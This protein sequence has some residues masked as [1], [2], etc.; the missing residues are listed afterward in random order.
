MTSIDQARTPKPSNRIGGG[1]RFGVPAAIQGA[2]ASRIVAN[3]LAGKDAPVIR[4]NV[5]VE[6]WTTKTHDVVRYEELE[7]VAPDEATAKEIATEQVNARGG[8]IEVTSAKAVR[9]EDGAVTTTNLTAPLNQYTRFYDE[10]YNLGRTRGATLQ[11]LTAC[12]AA[13]VE[14]RGHDY[15]EGQPC[16]S[17]DEGLLVDQAAI[18]GVSPEQFAKSIMKARR[19]A[20]NAEFQRQ[21]EIASEQLVA[22]RVTAAEAESG[23]FARLVDG[24]SFGT[25]DELLSY[26]CAQRALWIGRA[27]QGEEGTRAVIFARRH[28]ADIQSEAAVAV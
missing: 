16:F 28:W 21:Y 19:A 22:A 18:A 9:I 3:G 10:P 5:T 11:Y 15:A 12:I 1:E 6:Y 27:L 14:L 2:T 24:R 13:T 8:S 20:S 26:V 25:L 4:F 17:E 23:W 7:I